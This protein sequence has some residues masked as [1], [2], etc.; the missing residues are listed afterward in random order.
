MK[1][2]SEPRYRRLPGR[3]FSAVSRDSLWLA[4]DHILSV[5]SNRFAETYRRYYLRDIQAVT[6]QRAAAVSPW[7]YVAGAIALLLLAPGLFFDFQRMLL[8]G[9][10]AIFLAATLAL[11]AL[12]PTCVCH[13]H[14]AVSRDRLAS[15]RWVRTAERTIGI[16]R[17]FIE[18]FQGVVTADMVQLPAPP[19]P[20]PASPAQP[21]PL[22]AAKEPETGWGYEFLFG[23][24]LLESLHSYLSLR[25]HGNVITTTAWILLAT[26]V[27]CIAW[28]LVRQRRFAVPRPVRILVIIALI[29]GAGFIYAVTLLSALSRQLRP[30]VSEYV[31]YIP[32]HITAIA[33]YAL[34]GVSGLALITRHRAFVRQREFLAS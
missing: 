32:L 10:G 30:G 3:P 14:T 28:L 19:P 17:P 9:S 25:H 11:I 24:F 21:P 33:V 4:D 15:L 27:I 20:L 23:L 6:V 29:L 34:L 12:G 26:E 13:M 5:Q 8:W 31:G 16:L 7:S 18:Q 1:S 22:P 2:P